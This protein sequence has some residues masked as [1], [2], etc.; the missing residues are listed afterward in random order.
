MGIRA[1]YQTDILV[2]ADAELVREA[3]LA[4]L[5]ESSVIADPDDLLKTGIKGLRR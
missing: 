1:H 5:E 4:V 3:E 2:Q